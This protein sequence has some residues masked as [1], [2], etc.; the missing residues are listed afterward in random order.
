[1]KIVLIG[2]MGTGK[3]SL[4]KLL[5]RKLNFTFIDTD[6]LIEERQGRSISAIFATDGEPFFRQLEREL[7]GELALIQEAVISTGGGFP[8]NPENIQVLR[9][10]GFIVALTATPE[11]IYQRIKNETHRPLLAQTDP[12]NRIATLLKT[13]AAVY[14]NSDLTLDTTHRT[15]EAMAAEV[16]AEVRNRGVR[17]GKDQA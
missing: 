4:G 13:R 3:S 7:A 1:M 11:V 9:Q 16:M 17:D 5:A 15:L 6:A 14:Q 8:L 12:L 10:D 2:F